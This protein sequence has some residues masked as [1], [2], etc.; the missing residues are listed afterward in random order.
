MLSKLGVH[1]VQR[2]VRGGVQTHCELGGVAA[3]T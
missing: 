3:R 1:N 2:T